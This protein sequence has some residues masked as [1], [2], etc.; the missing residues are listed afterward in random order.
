MIDIVVISITSNYI[1]IYTVLP[2]ESFNIERE[3]RNIY[4]TAIC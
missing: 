4:S 2:V 1:T 3:R